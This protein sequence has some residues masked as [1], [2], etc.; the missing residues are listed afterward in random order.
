MKAI[1]TRTIQL[2]RVRPGRNRLGLGRRC[3]GTLCSDGSG[4]QVTAEPL[5]DRRCQHRPRHVTAFAAKGRF[6]NWLMSSKFDVEK[7]ILTGG[8]YDSTIPR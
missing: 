8:K 4:T 7:K 6:L 2:V 1:S 5:S 3:G